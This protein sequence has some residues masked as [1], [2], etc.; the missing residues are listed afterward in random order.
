[1]KD[2]FLSGKGGDTAQGLFIAR[3]DDDRQELHR[4]NAQLLR[5][6]QRARIEKDRIPGP[7]QIALVA[8][9]VDHLAI[10]HVDEFNAGMLEGRIGLG[11]RRQR[12]QI[13]L[14]DQVAT[15]RMT[16]KLVAVA[17]FGATPL[18]GQAAA[19]LDMSDVALLFKLHEKRGNRNI[20]RFRQH[21]KRG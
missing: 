18:D 3:V 1:M 12:D 8:V 20:Q 2:S 14:D 5:S 16:E 6:V 19:R 17:G 13:G 11:V 9:P 4:Q 21:L 7:Q 10:Q 15:Q